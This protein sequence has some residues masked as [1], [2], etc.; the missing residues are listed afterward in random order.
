MHDAQQA[1][2]AA[3]RYYEQHVIAWHALGRHSEARVV[4]DAIA[5]QRHELSS[6]RDEL[7]HHPGSTHTPAGRAE[8]L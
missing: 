2:R 3:T 4:R 6:E 1:L 8:W 5:L 7:R